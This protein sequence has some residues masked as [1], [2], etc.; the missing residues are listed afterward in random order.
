MPIDIEEIRK[1]QRELQKKIDE[2]KRRV[3]D[4]LKKEHERRVREFERI[5]KFYALVKIIGY[6]SYKVFVDVEGKTQ[7]IEEGKIVVIPLPNAVPLVKAGVAHILAVYPKGRA[8]PKVKTCKSCGNRLKTVTYYDCVVSPS[9]SS[10]E[11][12]KVCPFCGSFF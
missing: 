9:K 2:T 1:K 6:T 7:Y 4:E 5:E 3:L 8:P 12:K 10:C 11:V